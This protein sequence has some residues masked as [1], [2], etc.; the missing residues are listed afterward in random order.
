[1]MQTITAFQFH[2]ELTVGRNKPVLL[3]CEDGSGNTVEVVA[4]F[5]HRCERGSNALI[6]EAIAAMFAADLH[7]PVPEPFV[8]R[9]DPSLVDSLFDRLPG[10]Q[11]AVRSVPGFGSRLLPPAY[12]LL[13]SGKVLSSAQ[14]QGAVEIVAFD[15]LIQNSDRLPQ[16]PNCLTNGVNLA[17]IDHELA[18]LTDI[19]GWRPP[20][21][22]GAITYLGPPHEHLLYSNVRGYPVDLAG[23][24][25]RLGAVDDARLEDYLAALP[26][27]WI[28]SGTQEQQMVDQLRSMRT[29]IMD[30]VSELKRALR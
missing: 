28:G 22:I 25:E 2:R 26:D 23:L 17:I 27:S 3:S 6:A 19:I 12:S 15:V 7:L 4:K 5:N 21:E 10:R 11:P 16:N 29:H 8:V 13:L 1:M 9:I 14:K 18:F 24:A 30:I 20:W